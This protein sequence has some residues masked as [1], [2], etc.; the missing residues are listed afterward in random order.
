M[1]LFSLTKYLLFVTHLCNYIGRLQ[2]DFLSSNP[3]IS[4]MQ[5]SSFFFPAVFHGRNANRTTTTARFFCSVGEEASN[6]T[7]NMTLTVGVAQFKKHR[8]ADTEAVIV[9]LF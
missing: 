6:C 5:S 2:R 3:I 4:S 9:S 7:T 1:Q 8:Y